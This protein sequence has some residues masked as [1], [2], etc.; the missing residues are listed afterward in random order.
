MAKDV[1]VH[2]VNNDHADRCVDFL[3]HPDGSFGFKEYRRDPEDQG[4]WFVT[5]YDDTGVYGSYEL[6]LA[7]AWRRVG[8]LSAALRD[9]APFVP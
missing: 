4:A 9:A 6:A 1:V 8:W 7:A 2:S 3:R 5:A